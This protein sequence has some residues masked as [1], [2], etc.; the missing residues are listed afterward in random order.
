MK[1][2]D[3]FTLP[4][5][6]LGL[7]IIRCCMRDWKEAAARI[8]NRTR[9][10]KWV[11]ASRVVQSMAGDI[12]VNGSAMANHIRNLRGLR[13]GN[14][15]DVIS[16]IPAFSM[17]IIRSTMGDFILEKAVYRQEPLR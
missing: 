11:F 12:A 16:K 15:N 6:P 8:K 3:A 4:I 13:T 14:H 7:H 1:T 5:P 9:K 2:Q 10:S 17:Q